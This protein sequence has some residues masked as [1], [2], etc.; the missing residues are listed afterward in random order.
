MIRVVIYALTMP[1]Q[2]M[3][4]GEFAE[5]ID[6]DRYE[7]MWRRLGSCHIRREAR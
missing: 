3:F 4:F 7:A 6:A 1:P 2:P 5:A